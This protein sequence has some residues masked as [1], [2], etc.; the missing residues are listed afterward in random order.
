[1]TKQVASLRLGSAYRATVRFRWLSDS[2]AV[3]HSAFRASP[4]C[5]QPDPRPDIAVAARAP[6]EGR[7]IVALRN[8]GRA[9]RAFDVEL[10]SGGRQLATRRV[11]GMRAGRGDVMVFS[12]VDC[13]AGSQVTVTV[14]PRGELAERDELNNVAQ[15]RCPAAG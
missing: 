4:S 5:V 2:G 11:S 14:D 15:L 1:M 3:V 7:F 6:S 8:S 12:G 9:S 13:Q 10:S